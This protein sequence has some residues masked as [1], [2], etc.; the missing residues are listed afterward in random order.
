MGGL[1]LSNQLRRN[2]NNKSA[3]SLRKRRNKS[4]EKVVS[5]SNFVK[6]IY[7]WEKDGNEGNKSAHAAFPK[8]PSTTFKTPQQLVESYYNHQIGIGSNKTGSQSVLPL[9]MMSQVDITPDVQ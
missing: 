7:G 6:D 5:S 4:K 8:R 9:S 3:H 1:S 2:M